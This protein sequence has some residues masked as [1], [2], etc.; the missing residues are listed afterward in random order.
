MIFTCYVPPQHWAC[1]LIVFGCGNVRVRATLRFVCTPAYAD[2]LF[3]SGQRCSLPA[4]LKSA[5]VNTLAVVSP[6]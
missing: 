1:V 4:L 2:R 3:V 5:Q 6:C